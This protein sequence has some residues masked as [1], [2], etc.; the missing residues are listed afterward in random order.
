MKRD[1]IVEILNKIEDVKIAVFGDFMLDKYIVGN[2]ERISPEAPVP[3]VN[4]I[5]EY[6]VLS[7]NFLDFVVTARYI[8]LPVIH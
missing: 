8:L 5:K 6:S 4:V 7:E 2:V 3:I 1:R